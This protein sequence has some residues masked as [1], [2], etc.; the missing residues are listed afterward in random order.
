MASLRIERFGSDNLGASSDP[1][2]LYMTFESGPHDFIDDEK[3][4]KELEYL[5]AWTRPRRALASDP[6]PVMCGRKIGVMLRLRSYAMSLF[7]AATRIRLLHFN[8]EEVDS[9]TRDELGL[10]ES[11]LRDLRVLKESGNQRLGFSALFSFQ[12][13]DLSATRSCREAIE[14]LPMMPML[15]IKNKG[16]TF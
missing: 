7:E 9:I 8:G 6:M 14:S 2:S 4:V 15:P 11:A 1:C 3:L 12:C 13:G 16:M 10:K 5:Y